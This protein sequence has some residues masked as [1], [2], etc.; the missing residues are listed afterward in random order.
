MRW[1]EAKDAKG[2]KVGGEKSNG[3]SLEKR[4]RLVRLAPESRQE[5]SG[6]KDDRDKI[7]LA[8]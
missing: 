2:V 4:F 6:I 8:P 5:R 3:S 7:F 1:I